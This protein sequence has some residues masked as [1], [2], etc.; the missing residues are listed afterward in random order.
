[1]KKSLGLEICCALLVLLFVYASLSKYF[2]FSQFRNDMHNQP[3]PLWF[4]NGVIWML[5]PTELLIATALIS[6]KFRKLGLWCALTLMSL[7]TLYTA[8][9]KLHVF[10]KIPCSCSGVLKH[11]SWNQHLILNISFVAIA[12]LGIIFTKPAEKVNS[13]LSRYV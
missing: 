4:S 11:L 5:P 3:F 2:P 12:T 8:A 9:A 13:N 1:M 6:L 7:F 10:A